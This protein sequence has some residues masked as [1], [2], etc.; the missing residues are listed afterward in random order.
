MSQYGFFSGP[1]A[2]KYGP[3][4]NSVFGHFS[5]SVFAVCDFFTARCLD[6]RFQDVLYFYLLE[7]L[8]IVLLASSSQG[9]ECVGLTVIFN[10]EREEIFAVSL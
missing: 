7:V 3:E 2:G 5:R 4:K 9:R 6:V 1:N 8:S 10:K